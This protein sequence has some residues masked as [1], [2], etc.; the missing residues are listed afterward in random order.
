MCS[1]VAS[2][3]HVATARAI[4]FL[5]VLQL[6]R[7]AVATHTYLLVWLH[8]GFVLCDVWHSFLPSEQGLLCVGLISCSHI[9]CVQTVGRAVRVWWDGE[10]S[11]YE[12]IVV[13]F[14][15]NPALEDSHG[16][17]PYSSSFPAPVCSIPTHFLT[18]IT[19]GGC[20]SESSCPFS[21]PPHNPGIAGL[22]SC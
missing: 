1:Q 12:G 8:P 11:W 16:I 3:V 14:S 13:R 19:G 20:F 2:A 10:K 18:C 21:S 5:R 6:R 22:V 4:N 15:S 7:G 9:G 17:Y